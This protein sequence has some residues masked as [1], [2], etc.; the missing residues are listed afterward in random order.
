MVYSVTI[1]TDANT[2]KVNAKKTVLKLT[3]GLVWKI[4]IDFPPGCSGLLYTQIFDGSYQVFPA[5]PGTAF[6]SDNQLIGFD[7]LYLKTSEP[8][9]FVI[10]TWNLDDTWPHTIQIHLG[11]ASSEAFMSRYMPSKTWEKFQDVLLQVTKDQEAVKKKQLEI[12]TD[13]LKDF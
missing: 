6:H 5:S 12:L 3:K 2:T 1:T 8:F 9:E 4:E 10:K 13:E 11:M 7:D